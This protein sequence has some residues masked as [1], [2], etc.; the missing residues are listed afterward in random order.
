MKSS[1]KSGSFTKGEKLFED[2]A[3]TIYQTD[4]EQI[5]V[6]SFR[7][8]LLFSSPLFDEPI[9][10]RATVNNRISAFIG[11]HLNALHISTHFIE[12]LNM[13]EQLIHRVDIL[14]LQVRVRNWVNDDVASHLGLPTG[15]KMPRPIT[16]LYY[17]R[18]DGKPVLINDDYA[19]AMN[20]ATMAEL[21]DILSLSLRSNDVLMGMFS[22]AGFHLTDF[23]LTFGRYINHETRTIQMVIADDLT[24]DTCNLVDCKTGQKMGGQCANDVQNP[25]DANTLAGTYV[26]IGE[27]LNILS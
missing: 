8:D 15:M 23:S 7:D 3:K 27:R 9:L 5:L 11:N 6:Q 14:P 1:L 24:P 4:Q 16:E 25:M 17:L 22:V 12:R 21:E 18:S 20:W 19:L 13:F 26:T 2:N 10:G